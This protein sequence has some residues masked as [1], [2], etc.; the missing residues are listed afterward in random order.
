MVRSGGLGDRARNQCVARA[1][2]AEHPATAFLR[3]TSQGIGSR[4]QRQ[5]VAA[6]NQPD[7]QTDLDG[8]IKKQL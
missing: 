2:V 8:R 7:N 6:R 5:Q 4:Q 1:Q 3:V